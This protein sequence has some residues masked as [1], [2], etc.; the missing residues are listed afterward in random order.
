MQTIQ[1]IFQEFFTMLKEITQMNLTIDTIRGNALETLVQLI[2]AIPSVPKNK[3]EFIK[4]F[5]E[6]NFLYMISCVEDADQQWMSP[7][8]GSFT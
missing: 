8:E 7:P 2:E 4:E 6:C 5:F 1:A 3:T